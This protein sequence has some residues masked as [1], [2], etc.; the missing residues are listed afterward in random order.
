MLAGKLALGDDDYLKCINFLFKNDC[1]GK[2]RDANGWSLMDEAID[3]ANSRMLA[4]VF[5]NLNIK[6]KEKIERNKQ[7]ILQRL[8]KIPDFYTEIRWECQSNFIPFLS[9]F[10]PSDNFQIWKIGSSIRLD[11]SLVG[12]SKLQNKRRRMSILFRDS[13]KA[14]DEFKGVDIIM[15]NHDR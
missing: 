15:V 4:I 1:D 9:K 6:K 2:L 7:R 10:A 13:S 8:E 11:F 3:Q 12:F 5:S 14:N